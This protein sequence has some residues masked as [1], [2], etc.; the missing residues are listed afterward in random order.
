MS[1]E[2]VHFLGHSVLVCVCLRVCL[3]QLYTK[4]CVNVPAMMGMDNKSNFKIATKIGK[5]A[6]ESPS[7]TYRIYYTV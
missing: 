1:K 7:S 4:S 3:I 6:Q 2:C 5:N